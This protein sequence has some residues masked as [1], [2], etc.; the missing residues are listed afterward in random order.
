MEK[1]ISP[2]LGFLNVALAILELKLYPRIAPEIH[3]SLPP[4]SRCEPALLGLL[5]A[6]ISV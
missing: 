6:L 2:E 5:A 3:L 1:K 4:E